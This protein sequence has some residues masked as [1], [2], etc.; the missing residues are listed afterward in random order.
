MRCARRLWKSDGSPRSKESHSF[1]K[2]KQAKCDFR[3]LH[4]LAIKNWHISVCDEIERAAE[5]DIGTFYKTA[6]KNT[7]KASSTIPNN[8]EYMDS[9]AENVL[10]LFI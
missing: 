6:W 10:E 8:L 1:V 4:R 3:K 2:Y 9:K 5:L 7:K